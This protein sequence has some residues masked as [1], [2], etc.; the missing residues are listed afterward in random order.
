MLSRASKNAFCKEGPR[1]QTPHGSGSAPKT[2]QVATKPPTD[3]QTKAGSR[4]PSAESWQ[5]L[6]RANL[7]RR[8]AKHVDNPR[9]R[10]TPAPSQQAPIE[11]AREARSTGSFRYTPRLPRVS[12]SDLLGRARAVRASPVTQCLCRPNPR[13][14]NFRTSRHIE[15]QTSTMIQRARMQF[16]WRR[17]QIACSS[18]RR[19][20]CLTCDS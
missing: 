15:C 9:Q 2:I 11:T 3:R 17:L 13:A 16:A 6:K 1:A 8:G 7:I 5:S 14:L 19:S 4:C 12:A 20:G 18:L 10:R